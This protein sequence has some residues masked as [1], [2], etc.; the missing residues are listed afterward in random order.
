MYFS[1]C[2][3]MLA[4]PCHSCALSEQSPWLYKY[5]LQHTLLCCR[6]VLLLLTL[7][8]P[9]PPTPTRTPNSISIPTPTPTTHTQLYFAGPLDTS[10]RQL[11]EAGLLNKAC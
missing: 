8:A 4:T 5:S 9:H 3:V 2:Y 1:K 11:R 10:M 7:S 6:R